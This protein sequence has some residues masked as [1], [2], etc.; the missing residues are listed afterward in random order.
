MIYLL[1]QDWSNTSNNHAGMKY[2]CNQ[3][4][5]KY[6]NDYKSIVIPDFVG[7]NPPRNRIFRKWV[8]LKAKLNHAILLSCIYR[9][10][11]KTIKQG[12]VVVLMEYMDLLYRTKNFAYKI[13]SNIPGVSLYAMVHLVPGKLNRLFSSN[14]ELQD[15]VRPIDK[16]LTLGS[17]LTDYFVSRGIDRNIIH[18][19]FHYVDEYYFKTSSI[20]ISST[21]VVIAMGNQMRNVKMLKEVVDNNQE[22]NFVICQGLQDMSDV[23]SNNKNVKLIPFV[24]EE[25]LREYMDK[26]DI[27]LNIMED[28]IGS[29]VIVTSLAM[30]LAMICSDVGSIRDYCSNK[31]TLF[32]N[33]AKDFTNAIRLLS[34]D[35]ELLYSM[36]NNALLKYN[37]LKIEAF[38]DNFQ[39]MM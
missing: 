2:L 20:S 35:K 23:F 26:A 18:T 21:P 11:V 10:L 34:E 9:K 30:G 19:T 25:E 31:D 13:K 6:P 36:K 39:N 22:V 27:S 33:T 38:H 4:Q 32:C 16:I 29:N 7:A 8:Y 14:D 37:S 17:S 28:T 1:S 3:L 24:R 5:E 12:D 15:W